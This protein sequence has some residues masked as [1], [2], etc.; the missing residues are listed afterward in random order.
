MSL[1]HTDLIML[2]LVANCKSITAAVLSSRKSSSDRWI[3]N[4]LP[5]ELRIDGKF[6]IIMVS[7]IEIVFLKVYLTLTGSYQL[8]PTYCKYP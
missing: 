2:H 1:L 6:S 8:E 7:R 4:K 5:Y 3:S